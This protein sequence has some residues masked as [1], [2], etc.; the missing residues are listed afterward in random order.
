MTIDWLYIGFV[1]GFVTAAWICPTVGRAF[2]R[3]DTIGNGKCPLR[4]RG[5]P[6]H[7]WNDGEKDHI[8]CMGW[9]DLMTDELLEECQRCPDHVNKAQGDLDKWREA[10]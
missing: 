3:G 2:R 7:E 9:I 6:S 10:L 1:L 5:R 4:K 8:Y